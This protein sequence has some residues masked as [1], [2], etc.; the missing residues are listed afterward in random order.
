MWRN[1]YIPFR[2]GWREIDG[3]CGD[4]MWGAG[5]LN[6]INCFDPDVCG[7]MY[8]TAIGYVPTGWCITIFLILKMSTTV[9]RTASTI[10]QNHFT[11]DWTRRPHRKT[12]I[13]AIHM[14][15]IN[16]I[17]HGDRTVNV[18][19]GLICSRTACYILLNV[20]VCVVLVSIRFFDDGHRVMPV[21]L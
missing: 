12:P 9:L 15:S 11:I 16:S 17:V 6:P 5:V 8:S 2:S 3:M 4:P 20:G 21:L 10:G 14:Y 7:R 19:D 18:C 13:R 1:G